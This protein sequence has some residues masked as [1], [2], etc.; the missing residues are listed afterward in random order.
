MTLEEKFERLYELQ[1]SY[2]IV[3]S[4]T[5]GEVFGRKFAGIAHYSSDKNVW[6]NPSN[7][8]YSDD[9]SETVAKVLEA[10]ENLAKRRKKKLKRLKR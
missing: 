4:V 5:S 1:E 2:Y 9:L 3:W 8:H 7:W 10:A 6:N